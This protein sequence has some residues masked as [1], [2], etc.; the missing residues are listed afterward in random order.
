LTSAG[1]ALLL[2]AGASYLVPFIV[3]LVG[4]RL[5]CGFGCPLALLTRLSEQG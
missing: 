1:L 5:F 4:G 2:A 3:N